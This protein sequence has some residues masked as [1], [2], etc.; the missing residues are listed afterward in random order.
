MLHYPAISD[1]SIDDKK[2][3]RVKYIAPS[4]HAAIGL[5]A[6][7]EFCARPISDSQND[8][9]RKVGEAEP[10]VYWAGDIDILK[11]PC[12]SVIGAREVSAEGKAR[13]TRIARELAKAG[14][15]VTSGLAKG[16]DT[17]SHTG[18]LGAGG[19]TVAVIGTPL[20]KAYPN[21]NSELQQE[22]WRRHL[23]VSQFKPGQRTFPSDFPKRN[24]L[25]AALS[26]ASVI[27]E[28]SDTSGT[29]HQAV[30]CV[31]L[32]RWLFIMKSVVDDPRLTWPAKFL[33]E[34]RVVVLT[35]PDDVISR[36]SR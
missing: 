2:A 29:L 30:E 23:L 36:V 1:G 20:D 10:L 16:V 32:N 13:A 7:L 24:R 3:S 5:S 28:A 15:V 31:R 33:K 21:E 19:S 14:I 22:I 25:M 11:A 6:L 35:S 27:V 9:F 17:A 12:V 34:P 8:L 26:D 18:A 4:D